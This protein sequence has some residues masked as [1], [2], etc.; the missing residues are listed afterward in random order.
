MDLT[1]SQDV[2]IDD[3]GNRTLKFSATLE[4]GSPLPVWL[5]F[6]SSARK[7][8]GTPADPGS[9]RIRI[10]ATDTAGAV[11]STDFTLKVNG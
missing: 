1:F 7:F 11:V 3:D 6:R 10:T 4:D 8:S 2:F 9:Y 5:R